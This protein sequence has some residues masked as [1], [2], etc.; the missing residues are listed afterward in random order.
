MGL[1]NVVL[2]YNINSSL[3]SR[4]G[5]YEVTLK[6]MENVAIVPTK[7]TWRISK[8]VS[9]MPTMLPWRIWE[10]VAIMP[11]KLPWGIW[12]KVAI[13]PTKLMLP[14]C[15][16]S[17][18]E[19]YGKGR[20]GANEVYL[21]DKQTCFDN[22]NDVTLKDM[23]KCCH[24]ANEVTLRDMEKGRHSANEVNVAMMPTTLPW[25]IWKKVVMVPT[26]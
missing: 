13:V 2:N 5:F 3:W 11:T 6:D 26:K 4:F 18:P 25:R 1:F 10:N 19:G 20:H 15:Q 9:I 12:K 22:A 23:G 16:R 17:Y 24:N 21:K 7:L 14:W 8:H